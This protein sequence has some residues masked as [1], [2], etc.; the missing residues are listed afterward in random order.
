MDVMSGVTAQ[1]DEGWF[2]KLSVSLNHD[3]FL[4]LVATGRVEGV[5]LDEGKPVTEDGEVVGVTDEFKVLQREADTMLLYKLAR[6]RIISP[7]EARRRIAE[8]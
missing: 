2:R 8:L 7:E 6:E 4:A 3:D 5:K 1:N